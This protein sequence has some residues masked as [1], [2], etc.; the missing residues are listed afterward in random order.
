MNKKGMHSRV[1]VCLWEIDPHLQVAPGQRL[2]DCDGAAV[3]CNKYH[4]DFTLGPEDRPVF[5]PVPLDCL[6]ALPKTLS[7]PASASL[8]YSPACLIPVCVLGGSST[9]REFGRF[10][11]KRTLSCLLGRRQLSSSLATLGILAEW[12]WSRCS[13]K[14][15][16]VQDMEET[17]SLL[18]S[19]KSLMPAARQVLCAAMHKQSVITEWICHANKHSFSSWS[20]TDVLHITRAVSPVSPACWPV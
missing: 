17:L 15:S 9:R 6:P 12:V 4:R 18:S 3:W 5:L 8:A 16:W 20:G 10:Q 19:R 11:G 14:L 13:P 7:V 1:A 2:N